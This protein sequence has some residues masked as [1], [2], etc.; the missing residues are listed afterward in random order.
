MQWNPFRRWSAGPAGV[1]RGEIRVLTARVPSAAVRPVPTRVA[2]VFA[3]GVALL[4]LV[5]WGTLAGA[6]RLAAALVYENPLFTLQTLDVSSDGRLTPELLRQ[7]AGVR[8]GDNLFAVDLRRVREDLLS[9]PLVREVRVRRRLPNG[10]EV[11]V[12]ERTPLARLRMPGTDLPLAVDVEGWVLVGDGASAALPLLKGFP[13]PGLRPGLQLS[14]P[15]VRDALLLLDHCARR[16]AFLGLT[17]REVR[18]LDA[19]TLVLVLDT[20]DEVLLPRR[21]LLERL[22]DLPDLLRHLRARRGASPGP[23]QIDLTGEVNASVA[24]IGAG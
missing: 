14:S 13:T 23:H 20:G 19:E 24:P 8:A 4:A 22:D 18:R 3:A 16:R 6:R 21:R 12:T 5:G 17:P 15:E 1:R 11:R 2:A 10:L 9:V 7:Y